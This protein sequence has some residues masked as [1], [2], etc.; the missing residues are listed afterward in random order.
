ME[1]AYEGRRRALA[2]L[3]TPDSLDKLFNELAPRYAARQGGYTRVMRSR[4]REGD[5]APMAFVEFVDRPGELRAARPPK[6]ADRCV[7]AYA[8]RQG[9][10]SPASY[11]LC[12]HLLCARAA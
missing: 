4:M 11:L 7:R 6:G 8:R 9:I 10:G 12:R 1:D 3:R 2:V 5:G